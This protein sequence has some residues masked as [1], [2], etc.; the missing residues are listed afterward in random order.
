MFVR[1]Y[2][3]LYDFI[4]GLYKINLLGVLI[5]VYNI[6]KMRLEWYLKKLIFF[7]K[8]GCGFVYWMIF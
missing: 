3:Y 4:L 5:G 8:V 6:D 1:W 2:R 7:V